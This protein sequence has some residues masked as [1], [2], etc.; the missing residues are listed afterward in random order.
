MNVL[1]TCDNPPCG[2]DRH[3]FLGTQ[4]DNMIDCL[5]KGRWSLSDTG[6]KRKSR[7]MKRLRKKKKWGVRDP[8]TGQWM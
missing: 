5:N 8:I 6:R 7:F 4:S 1:H 3:L 2:N